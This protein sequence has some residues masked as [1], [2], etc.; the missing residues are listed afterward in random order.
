MN[1]SLRHR[2]RSLAFLPTSPAFLGLLAGLA[3]T[4]GTVRAQAPASPAP[5]AQESR[6]P[7]PR[8]F[9]SLQTASPP[10]RQ[11]PGTTQRAAVSVSALPPRAL[12]GEVLQLRAAPL[13]GVAGDP[14]AR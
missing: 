3:V 2:P 6:V 5:G 4:A 10:G 12:P 11:A 7:P 1:E 9:G 14:S 13:L 8:K